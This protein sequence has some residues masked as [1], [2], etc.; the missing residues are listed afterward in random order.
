MRLAPAPFLLFLICAPTAANADCVSGKYAGTAVEG[1]QAP[2]S[3]LIAIECEGDAV[4]GQ[5]HT[6]SGAMPIS[7][8]ESG[9]DRWRI[10]GTADGA[11][12][13]AEATRDGD[14]WKG[15]Y[16]VGSRRGALDLRRDDSAVPPPLQR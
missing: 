14:A 15:A 4:R 13:T 10:E 9:A 6:P 2:V 7:G 8:G 1:A 5:A 16:Q 3:V 11:P 12:V